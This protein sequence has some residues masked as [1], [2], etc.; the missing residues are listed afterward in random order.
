MITVSYYDAGDG[1][2]GS[3]WRS[4]TTVADCRGPS[5]TAVG[6]DA[7]TNARGTIR[8]TTAE[9]GD[10]HVEW[11]PTPALGQVAHDPELVTEHALALNQFDSC[12]KVYF[13]VRS[14]DAA[15]NAAAADDNGA[16]FAFGT[17]TIPGL[18]WKDGFER[19][20]P[21]GWT[22]QGEW[23]I[24]PPQGKGGTTQ[25]FTDP[26]AAY[27]NGSV[28]GQDLTGR[29]AAP[30]DYEKGSSDKAISPPQNA[31][32]WR[33][34]QLVVHRQLNAGLGDE[35]G[36]Y[37]CIN[38]PCYTI[39]RSAL[40]AVFDGGWSR[41]EYDVSGLVDGKSGIRIEFR[42]GALGGTGAGWTVDDVMLK[43]GALPDYGACGG[44]GQGPSFA[45]ATAAVDDDA[46]A[47]GGVTVS[48]RPA[49]AW[50]TGTTG[51]YAVYRG[52]APGFPADAA[53][54]VAAGVTALAYTDLGAPAGTSYYL[55]RAE[56]DETCSGGPKNGGVTD[57]NAAYVAV[58]QTATRPIP[59]EVT[60]LGAT[61]VNHAHV[62]LQW[63]AA[64]GA[65]G[66]HVKRAT[67]PAPGAFAT[68]ATTEDTLYEDLD[69]ASDRTTRFYLVRGVNA[70]DQEGP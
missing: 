64:A 24:G 44:C 48:W 57:A 54:R 5:I 8:F 12:Q 28:L 4:A 22:L 35:A 14:T 2:G 63:S 16:P 50:G 60:G 45:G 33:N 53:H 62:R 61:L 9:P 58:E 15:G 31:T 49:V 42:Q 32:T 21:G 25:G 43:N 27:N 6:V 10:T 40:T 47:A 17:F 52:P 46:C 51:T 26:L 36:I 67:S 39:Y 59:A 41:Q 19:S 23:E 29:G 38:G 20:T 30:G 70:C 34:T 1:H 68:L 56:N 7:L 13:R 11:G 69:Q 3:G 37:L 66:F 65:T 18:Y 55:V